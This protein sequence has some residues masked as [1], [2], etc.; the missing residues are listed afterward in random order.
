MERKI[1]LPAA[2]LLTVTLLAVAV[3][4][5]LVD[6]VPQWPAYHQFADDRTMLGVPNAHNVISN[7][8][9]LIV[10]AWGLVFIL[11]HPGNAVA[12]GLQSSYLV[13]FAGLILTG[14]GSAYYHIQPDNQT[15]VWDRLPM[16]VMFMGFFASVTGELMGERVAKRLLLPLLVV[17]ATSVLWWVWTESI[18]AGDLRAYGLVQFLPPVLV[19]LMLI[20]YPAPRHYPSYIVVMMLVYGLAKLC[21]QFDPDIY[22]ELGWISGHA[23]K[24]L[25]S[26]AATAAV[27]VML[28]RRRDWKT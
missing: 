5:L 1:T 7:L 11:G 16:T 26:S 2:G 28:S 14:L 25:L 24:H 3:V 9:F 23:L 8:G 27:L 10:G 4:F 15:L 19:V 21:E 17:G 18:G 20:M 6:P 22:R 13:F 12:G